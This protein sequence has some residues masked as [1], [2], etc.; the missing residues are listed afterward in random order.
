MKNVFKIAAAASLF[1]LSMNTFAATENVTA[2]IH[3]V[4][5]CGSQRPQ[6]VGFIDVFQL[7]CKIFIDDL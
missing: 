5:K 2:E 6:S 3:L 7:L 1:A 4:V